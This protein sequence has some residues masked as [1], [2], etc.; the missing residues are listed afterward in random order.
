MN[1]KLPRICKVFILS[2][3]SNLWIVPHAFAND[4]WAKYYIG[5]YS[6]ERMG[7]PV[8]IAVWQQRGSL[9]D[10]H[11]YPKM[12]FIG[13]IT[14]RD[15]SCRF[16]FQD[17]YSFPRYW[18]FN[19]EQDL[20]L[21]GK[22]EAFGIFAY[23]F[24]D[25]ISDEK[26]MGYKPPVRHLSNGQPNPAYREYRVQLETK[27]NK[28][29]KTVGKGFHLFQDEIGGNMF[30][31]DR[32]KAG[33]P[34]N[35]RPIS[36]TKI[37]SDLLS[38]LKTFR[39]KRITDKGYDTIWPNQDAFNAMQDPTHSSSMEGALSDKCMQRSIDSQYRLFL[40]G[41][42]GIYARVVDETS[43]LVTELKIPANPLKSGEE[44]PAKHTLFKRDK[45]VNWQDMLYTTA[46][47]ASA[48]AHC[49]SANATYQYLNAV[50]NNELERLPLP[51]AL[52]NEAFDIDQA[53]ILS[54]NGI[55]LVN[56]EKLGNGTVVI[57]R[58]PHFEEGDLFYFIEKAP[59]F[60]LG[61][62]AWLK[63]PL[64]DKYEIGYDM[65]V[66]HA[67]LSIDTAL[68]DQFNTEVLRGKLNIFSEP[69]CSVYAGVNQPNECIEF[70]PVKKRIEQV[71]VL[72]TS[73]AQAISI[74]KKLF[75]DFI[76][77][78]SP[79]CS[80]LPFC[81]KDSSVKSQYLNAVYTEDVKTV[82][83]LEKVIMA[84]SIKAYES[85]FSGLLQEDQDVHVTIIPFLLNEYIY[86]Y[87]NKPAQCFQPG[88]QSMKFEDYVPET[89]LVDGLGNQVWSAGGYSRETTYKMVDAD[90]VEVCGEVCGIRE[91]DMFGE[92]ISSFFNG[93][94]ASKIK[95]RMLEFMQKYD[96]RAPEVQ[97]FE[98]SLLFVHQ[99][100]SVPAK[101]TNRFY[102]GYY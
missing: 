101:Q 40:Q 85:M 61:L 43:V 55:A 53:F 84:S 76:E 96:C 27:Q 14:S 41:T 56:P 8:D 93:N 60:R 94:E 89:S 10:L 30:F 19:A 70:V 100:L 88:S 5:A 82:K 7:T 62:R 44:A 69:L 98:E 29:R 99:F 102:R 15:G 45:S 13:L 6:I 31:G 28:C 26:Y 22:V 67:A 50:K 72:K 83:A 75:P 3:L 9:D 87:Q 81:N 68:S 37:S 54:Q 18:Q 39:Q 21:M 12:A 48:K 77:P 38:T 17:N 57:S 2:I 73:K 80:T 34:D 33:I 47:R 86:A 74:F 20:N 23:G 51:D 16:R 52:A 11:K 95:G 59:G 97:Q 46:E 63:N 90:F 71:Y 25:M 65:P 35:I 32:G 36:R 42:S 78:S 66:E 1:T 92:F 91:A 4:D 58:S 24:E 79:D 49:D 64:N